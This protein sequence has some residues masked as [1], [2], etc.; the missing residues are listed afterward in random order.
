MQISIRHL[1][2]EISEPY[3]EGY[4]LTEA[5]AAAMNAA[6]GQAIYDAF[7]KKLNKLYPDGYQTADERKI[8]REFTE[9]MLD[10]EFPTTIKRKS[11]ADPVQALALRY[12]MDALRAQITA[13]GADW[14]LIPEGLRN[15]KAAALVASDPS[16][17]RKAEAETEAARQLTSNLLLEDLF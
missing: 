8:R 7:G 2:F 1:I 12:A 17:L 15:E 6:R 9:F 14:N 5:D 11:K 3:F 13:S 10:F 4:I 16:F